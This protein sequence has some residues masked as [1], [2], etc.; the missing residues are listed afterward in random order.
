MPALVL[1]HIKGKDLSNAL[2]KLKTDP[3][4]KFTVI[5]E[6]EAEY[7]KQHMPAEEK[8]RPEFIHAVEKSN[9][10]YKAGR[11]TRCR[12]KEDRASYL[13]KVWGNE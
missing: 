3:D 1:G 8:I 11:F 10:N 12:T 9:K 2:K 7:A 5:I 6:P 4:K 13:K